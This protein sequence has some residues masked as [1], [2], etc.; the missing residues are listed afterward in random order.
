MGRFLRVSTVTATVSVYIASVA[1]VLGALAT[2]YSQSILTGLLVAVGA[3]IA[4]VSAY[5]FGLWMPHQP[6]PNRPSAA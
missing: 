6:M 3:L 2:V 4:G 5:C 1:V